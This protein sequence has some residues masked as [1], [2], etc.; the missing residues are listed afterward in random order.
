MFYISTILTV[1]G[2]LGI[3]HAGLFQFY[4]STILTAEGLVDD[5]VLLDFNST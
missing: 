5:L 2:V 3:E 1:V 4:I